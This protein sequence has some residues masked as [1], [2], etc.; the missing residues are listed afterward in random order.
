MSV[1][2]MTKDGELPVPTPSGGGKSRINNPYIIN[3]KRDR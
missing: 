1:S 2:V 3:G